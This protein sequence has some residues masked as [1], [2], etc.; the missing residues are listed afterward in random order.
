MPYGYGYTR[1]FFPFEMSHAGAGDGLGHVMRV[2]CKGGNVDSAARALLLEELMQCRLKYQTA[3]RVEVLTITVGANIECLRRHGHIQAVRDPRTSRPLAWPCDGLEQFGVDS[4]ELGEPVEYDVPPEWLDA[5]DLVLDIPLVTNMQAS[6]PGVFASWW[7]D[8]SCD[9]TCRHP[10]MFT[11]DFGFE[12]Y[13]PDI[14]CTTT[15]L[16]PRT[17]CVWS[18]FGGFTQYHLDGYLMQHSAVRGFVEHVVIH[19]FGES[20]D[21]NLAI[22]NLRI[23]SVEV[24]PELPV[25]HYDS[26]TLSSTI[27]CFRL[28]DLLF[29][30]DTD[31]LVAHEREPCE[32]LPS[33][34]WLCY[35]FTY[36]YTEPAP[37]SESIT[38]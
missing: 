31:H 4:L 36:R 17:L 21:T 28:D 30:R 26:D 29:D 15:T 25:H 27:S 35:A 37:E 6:H 20:R 38:I 11:I 19:T 16:L 13:Y 3:E 12:A 8:S 1:K 22:V 5:T 34:Q 2:C 23:N 33:L 14:V 32:Q 9:I 7:A 24:S 18:I 10:N